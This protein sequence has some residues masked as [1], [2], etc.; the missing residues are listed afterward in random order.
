ML[1][2][3]ETPQSRVA[4]L[5]AIMVLYIGGGKQHGQ[6]FQLMRSELDTYMGKLDATGN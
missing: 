1:Y 2:D 5:S 3:T 4:E 6:L